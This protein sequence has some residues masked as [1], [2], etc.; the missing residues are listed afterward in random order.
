MLLDQLFETRHEP[1]RTA[2]AQSTSEVP[3]YHDPANQVAVEE[4]EA[5]AELQHLHD[6]LRECAEVEHCLMG[7]RVREERLL[8][9]DCLPGTGQ[10]GDENDRVLRDAAL[11]DGI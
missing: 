7:S 8:A 10:A 3:V 1:I 5:L 4:V 9:E 11:K 6:G 2:G